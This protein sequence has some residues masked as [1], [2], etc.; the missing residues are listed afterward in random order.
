MRKL[1]FQM[2]LTNEISEEAGH[3]ILDMYY[4]KTTNRGYYGK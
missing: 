2:I 4:L 3:K 1:I